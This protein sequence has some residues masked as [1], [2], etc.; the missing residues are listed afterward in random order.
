M[1]AAV[2][3]EPALIEAIRRSPEDDLV[4]LV[5]A[6][7]LEERGEPLAAFIRLQ[8]EMN[9]RGGPT[10]LRE[11]VQRW[12]AWNCH[13]SDLDLSVLGPE[14]IRQSERSLITKYGP[15]P[16]L[17]ESEQSLLN[18]HEL[19][20]VGPLLGRLN[21]WTERRLFRRGFVEH[22]EVTADEWL[23]SAADIL[24]WC[25][26]LQSLTLNEIIGKLSDL[27]ANLQ[28]ACVRELH[29]DTRTPNL[30]ARHFD[31]DWHRTQV[32][33]PIE[34]LNDLNALM[35]WPNLSQTLFLRVGDNNCL[36]DQWLR[37]LANS[38]VQSQLA[39]VDL[40]WT[41]FLG[42]TVEEMNERQ[43]QV[44]GIFGRDLC[45]VLNWDKG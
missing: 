14:F 33:W 11:D 4:R 41:D 13:W 44:N 37:D 36:G 39:R 35:N 1:S 6:D 5:F 21:H 30:H 23:Q 7:W 29:L 38:P 24:N 45:E 10:S 34:E 42:G 40:L 12:Q 32:Y 19:T 27:A 3:Y 8:C 22:L 18:L 9:H 25:P 26:I 16:R 20:W 15:A 28:L 31:S 43:S 17:S 2:L